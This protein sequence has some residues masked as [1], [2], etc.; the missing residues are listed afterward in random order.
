MNKEDQKQ[1]AKLLDQVGYSLSELFI[2]L[3]MLCDEKPNFPKLEI[4]QFIKTYE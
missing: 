3:V 4:R 2:S 1:V